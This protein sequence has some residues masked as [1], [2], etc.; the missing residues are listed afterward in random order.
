MKSPFTSYCFPNATGLYTLKYWLKKALAESHIQLALLRDLGGMGCMWQAGE[1]GA[2]QRGTGGE[3]A[4]LNTNDEYAMKVT[5]TSQSP[6]GTCQTHPFP[7]PSCTRGLP[8]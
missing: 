5:L 1:W 3:V 7:S 2:A 8:G 6:A 4:L